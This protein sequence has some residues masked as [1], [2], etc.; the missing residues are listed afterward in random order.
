[1]SK[2]NEQ[3]WRNYDWNV[4]SKKNSTAFNSKDL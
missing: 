4:Q 3:E 1:M 2:M